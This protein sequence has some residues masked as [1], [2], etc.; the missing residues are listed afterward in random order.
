MNIN[1]AEIQIRF[2]D[3]DVMG[4]VN[5]AVYLSYFEITRIHYFNIL[6]GESWDWKKTGILLV[7]NEIEY[8]LPILLHQ[9]PFIYMHLIE[10]GEKSFKLGYEIHI[11]QKIHTKGSSVLVC[12]DSVTN[13]SILVP[14][15]MREVL[16]NL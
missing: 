1:P 14:N 10:I 7:K 11:N 2:S 12:F 4:H 6:L 15:E 16:Q 8:L 13:Q 9:K 5:N 3:I